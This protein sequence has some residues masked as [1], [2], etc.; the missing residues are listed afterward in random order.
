MYNGNNPNR[1]SFPPQPPGY[2][3]PPSSSGMQEYSSAPPPGLGQQSPSFRPSYPPYSGQVPPQSYW[4]TPG[5][6]YPTQC[7]PTGFVG[8]YYGQ[9]PSAPAMRPQYPGSMYATAVPPEHTVSALPPQERVPAAPRA[10]GSRPEKGE[11]WYQFFANTPARPAGQKPEIYVTKRLDAVNAQCRSVVCK[12]H[13][14]EYMVQLNREGQGVISSTEKYQDMNDAAECLDQMTTKLKDY[15]T[16][17]GESAV[18]W[19]GDTLDRL[20][21]EPVFNDMLEVFLDQMPKLSGEEKTIAKEKIDR[22][23]QQDKRLRCIDYDALVPVL[24]ER[25]LCPVIALS[26]SESKVG[27]EERMVSALVKMVTSEPERH[28][29]IC[30]CFTESGGINEAIALWLK[31]TPQDYN[32]VRARAAK[33]CIDENRDMFAQSLNARDLGT[34]LIAK[35]LI[36]QHQ[37]DELDAMETTQAGADR[38]LRIMN[39]WLLVDSSSI[40]RFIEAL[41]AS[42]HSGH[43]DIKDKLSEAIKLKRKLVEGSGNEPQQKKAKAD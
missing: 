25:E 5:Y 32:A 35:K 37:K 10:K 11:S 3:V 40:D 16:V 29:V 27:R 12:E 22:W 36:T 20:S 19:L 15:C 43:K 6:P 30:E 9:V 18:N 1:P 42:G 17:C 4:G 13:M 21:Y 26:G 7:P 34:V 33:E 14:N 8:G 41:E 31:G 24:K 23:N 28:S 39:S 2:Y 38:V